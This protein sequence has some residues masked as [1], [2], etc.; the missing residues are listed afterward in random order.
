LIGGYKKRLDKPGRTTGTPRLDKLNLHGQFIQAAGTYRPDV[1]VGTQTSS[2]T[3]G[4]ISW[5]AGE[6]RL[7]DPAGDSRHRLRRTFY[8][9]VAG[10]EDMKERTK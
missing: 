1:T 8:T 3:G 7:V 4:D 10:A 6:G 2:P 5:L 9:S